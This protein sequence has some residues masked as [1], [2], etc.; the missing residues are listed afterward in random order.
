MSKLENLSRGE[1]REVAADV[2]WGAFIWAKTPQR[3][4]YWSRIQRELAQNGVRSEA[5]DDVIRNVPYSHRQVVRDDTGTNV[6]TRRLDVVI[7]ALKLLGADG[8]VVT[9]LEALRPKPLE[10]PPGTTVAP[11]PITDL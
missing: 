4:N 2:L 6:S 7:E 11:P 9:N 3:H 5:V 8:D 1:L 10:L